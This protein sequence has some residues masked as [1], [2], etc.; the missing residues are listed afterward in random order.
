VWLVHKDGFS[1]GESQV[2]GYKCWDSGLRAGISVPLAVSCEDCGEQREASDPMGR[3]T[4]PRR[5]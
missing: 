2:V 4:G 5:A 1:L 3:K